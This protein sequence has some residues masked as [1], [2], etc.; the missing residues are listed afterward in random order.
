[1]MLD[2]PL[3]VNRYSSVRSLYQTPVQGLQRFQTSRARDSFMC[4]DLPTLHHHHEKAKGKEMMTF[5][6][7][8][9]YI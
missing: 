5:M 2:V 7:A 4:F 8:K 1:M 3:K 9:K 6:A